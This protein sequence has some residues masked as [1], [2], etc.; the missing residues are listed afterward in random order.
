MYNDC[1]NYDLKENVC[2]F[3]WFDILFYI[4]KNIVDKS[5]CNV[6]IILYY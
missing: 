1:L 5:Y 3:V 2:F 4:H 6:K